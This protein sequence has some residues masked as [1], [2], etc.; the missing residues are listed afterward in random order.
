M[1]LF[2]IDLACVNIN[3]L[4]IFL[5]TASGAPGWHRTANLLRIN[6]I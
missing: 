4:S 1:S 2:C 3:W 5:D 6:L